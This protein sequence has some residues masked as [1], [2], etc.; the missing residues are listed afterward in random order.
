MSIKSFVKVLSKLQNVKYDRWALGRV[1][2]LE[3]SEKTANFPRAKVTFCNAMKL[4]QHYLALFTTIRSKP[5]T[6]VS[7]YSAPIVVTCF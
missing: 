3:H 7:R 6:Q 4:K 2:N 1:L 5:A